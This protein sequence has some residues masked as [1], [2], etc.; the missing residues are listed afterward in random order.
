MEMDETRKR[1]LI[2]GA[3][4]GAVSVGLIVLARKTPRD[5]WGETLGRIARDA[6]GLVKARYGNTEAVRMAE[7]ALDRAL[8]PSEGG[9]A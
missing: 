5:K 4:V 9:A 3:I 8:P 2:A 6:I 1:Y 7:S